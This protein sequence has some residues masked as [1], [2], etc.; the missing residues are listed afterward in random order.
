MWNQLKPYFYLLLL[1][2]LIFFSFYYLLTVVDLKN[3][4]NIEPITAIEEPALDL[5]ENSIFYYVDMFSDKYDVDVL[6]IHLVG[7]NES[8]WRYPDSL[9]YIRVC[10]DPNEDSLGD[11]Q[12]YKP[13]RDYYLD[14][15]NIDTITRLTLLEC[16]VA[17]MSDLLIKYDN[18]YTKVRYAY[19]RG[20][21]KN[22]K[23]WTK[24]E[25]KF[26]NKF[27]WTLIK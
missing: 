1:T 27:D 10:L 23:K 6:F 19:A 4:E 5:N 2:V 9:D 26:M 16:S 8:G 15:L 13:T 22:P 25:T 14:K 20:R 3:Y 18:D 21:W 7:D 17:Y 12:I 11:L 24:L